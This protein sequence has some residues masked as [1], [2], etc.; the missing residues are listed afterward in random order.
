MKR[1]TVKTRAAINGERVVEFSN[2]RG[3]GGLLSLRETDTRGLVLDLYR[4]DEEVTVRGAPL[5]AVRFIVD[6]YTQAPDRYGNVARWARIT[7]TVTG[8]SLQVQHVG[9]A[10]NVPSDVYK[11]IDTRRPNFDPWPSIHYTE[12]EVPRRYWKPP[13]EGVFESELTRQ[14]ILGLES[15]G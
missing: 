1:P 9:G 10:N 3:V 5:P 2:S 14:L 12:H 6:T 8:R 7:S 13:T 11:A 15:K 4:L